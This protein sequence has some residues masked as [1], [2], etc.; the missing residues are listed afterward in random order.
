MITNLHKPIVYDRLLALAIPLLESSLTGP[1]AISDSW[2]AGP[3]AYADADY[4][5]RSAS[6]RFPLVT[7]TE[8]TDIAVSDNIYSSGGFLSV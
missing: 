1:S 2:Y 5:L 4:V 7:P 3:Q 8:N 6:V